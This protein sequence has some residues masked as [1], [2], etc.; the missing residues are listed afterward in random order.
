MCTHTN[1]I[2]ITAIKQK[3]KDLITKKLFDT[4]KAPPPP[5]LPQPIAQLPPRWLEDGDYP[6]FTKLVTVDNVVLPLHALSV[7]TIVK[8][9]IA[10]VEIIQRYVNTEDKPI[11]AVYVFQFLFFSEK[12][13]CMC[14][15]N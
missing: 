12:L 5:L 14:G 11:E 8:Q 10:Q 2:Q 13:I 1:N 4:K 15:P 3:T 9:W 6:L 7:V